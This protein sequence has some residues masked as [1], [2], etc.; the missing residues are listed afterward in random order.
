M[1]KNTIKAKLAKG[2]A[3]LGAFLAFPSPDVVEMFGYLGFD[4]VLLD[5]EHGP[6]SVE[7]A[8]H[9]LRAAECSGIVPII[10]VPSHSPQTIA[11][12]LDIG[13]L[14]IQVPQV[15]DRDEAEAIVK[16][17]KFHPL[18]SRGM[19]RPRA[20][21]YG[22]VES[23][24]DYMADAN[25]ETMV[26]ASIENIEGVMHLPHILDTDG[27][28]VFLIGPNDLSQSMG[29][30]GQ[31]GTPLVKSAVDTIVTQVRGAGRAVGIYAAD[32]ATA[33]M[34]IAKGAQY[35][36]T[37]TAGLLSRAAGDYLGDVRRG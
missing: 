16:S 2:E 1:M 31:V 12:Y 28:D 30:P 34:Y 3:V 22:L 5:A 21:H 18:G 36:I 4:F 33:R 10:N 6:M 17:V 26:I 20:N 9:L 13:A 23:L 37:G 24:S 35:V 27:I 8:A 19:A 7:T 32:A 11:R 14:G 29:M 25:K 15:N